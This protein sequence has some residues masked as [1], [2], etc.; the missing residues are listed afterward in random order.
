MGPDSANALTLSTA[1]AFA[2]RSSSSLATPTRPLIAACMSAVSQYCA[3]PW[4]AGGASSGDRVRAERRADGAVGVVATSR[5]RHVRYVAAGLRTCCSHGTATL[6]GSASGRPQSLSRGRRWAHARTS[7]LSSMAAPASSSSRATST[8]PPIAAYIS[9]VCPFCTR[10]GGANGHGGGETTGESREGD[11][12]TMRGRPS[13]PPP[14]P[15]VDRTIPAS[16]QAVASG[17]VYAPLLVGFPRSAGPKVNPEPCG[18]SP[19][20]HT[21]P[22]RGTLNSNAHGGTR[23]STFRRERDRLALGKSSRPPPHSSR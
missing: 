9:G 2:P 20:P 15:T 4:V 21:G 23:P 3:S 17:G 7:L 13:R 16:D 6:C 1:A 12:A 19:T 5:H 18:A 8:W 10:A 11:A 22:T 14:F